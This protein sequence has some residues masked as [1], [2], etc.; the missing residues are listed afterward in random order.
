MVSLADSQGICIPAQVGIETNLKNLGLVQQ[1]TVKNRKHARFYAFIGFAFFPL[2]SS[3]SVLLVLLLFAVFSHL[4]LNYISRILR[5][6]QYIPLCLIL[7]YALSVV[8]FIIVKYLL[9]LVM[10]SSKTQSCAS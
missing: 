7:R 5:T 6:Q 8:L 1:E 2:N 9:I 3:A 4:I 10:P